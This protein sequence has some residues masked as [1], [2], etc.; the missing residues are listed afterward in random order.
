MQTTLRYELGAGK[1]QLQRQKQHERIKNDEHNDTRIRQ[2]KMALE[3]DLNADWVENLEET[4]IKALYKTNRV[5]VKQELL[6][7][8]K[9]LLRVRRA[10]L[11]KML[12]EEE[13]DIAM[14]LRD[15][16]GKIIYSD[17]I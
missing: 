6:N 9:A 7:A 5:S 14:R 15:E 11:I 4:R 12:N 1:V 8:N 3:A 10:E 2:N 13:Q 17:R 16:R